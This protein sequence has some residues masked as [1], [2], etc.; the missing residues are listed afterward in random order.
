M[1]VLESRLTEQVDTVLASLR[2][3]P[4]SPLDGPDYGNR[5]TE[6]WT[7]ACVHISGNWQGVVSAE[8]S[9]AMAVDI[10]AAM[11]MMEPD[12]LSEDEVRDALGEVANLLAGQFKIDL[13][14]GCAL[15]LP[16][17]TKGLDYLINVPGSQLSQRVSVA[18]AGQCMVVSVFE[19][20]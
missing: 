2:E 16:T 20:T 18:Q 4:V 15:S 11:F 17:V 9:Y 1:E 6:Y 5:G 19:G 7:T 8:C 10:A 3:D 13:P 14:E 12:E